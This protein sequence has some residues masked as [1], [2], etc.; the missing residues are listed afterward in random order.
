MQVLEASRAA[1]EK[2]R[3][4]RM[5][6]LEAS[7][8]RKAAK[9][10]EEAKQR[11]EKAAKK[12]EEAKQRMEA[13]TAEDAK[14]RTEAS[15]SPTEYSE[16]PK[17]PVRSRCEHCDTSLAGGLPGMLDVSAAIA[18]NRSRQASTTADR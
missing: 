3:A 18:E 17:R 10:A 11:T 4:E 6:V 13:K 14:Q 1:K 5:Q 9:K 7:R 8:A 16:I 12:A 15:V 2:L